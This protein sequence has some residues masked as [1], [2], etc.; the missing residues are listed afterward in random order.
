ML[1][2]IGHWGH[3]NSRLFPDNCLEAFIFAREKNLDG[4]ELDIY[5]T[6]DW[7]PVIIHENGN[8]IGQVKVFDI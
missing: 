1:L 4:I 5:L 7:I 3:T 2:N 8:E 6:K